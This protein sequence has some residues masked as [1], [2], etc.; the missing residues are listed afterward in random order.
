MHGVIL[1]GTMK[2]LPTLNFVVIL[3][4]PLTVYLRKTNNYILS[5]IENKI[6]LFDGA[7]SRFD[8]RK[9]CL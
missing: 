6:D 5:S 7:L 2:Q 8:G 1:K 3:R 9:I 4:T